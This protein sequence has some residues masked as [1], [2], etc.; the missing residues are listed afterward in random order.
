MNESL[1]C[2]ISLCAKNLTYFG[3]R[4]L[5]ISPLY[6]IKILKF[7]LNFAYPYFVL[8]V[9]LILIFHQRASRVHLH[10]FIH[11]IVEDIYHSLIVEAEATGYSIETEIKI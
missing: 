6:N 1:L 5:R 4:I 7:T 3:T 8:L 11:N 10:A 9:V 2:E